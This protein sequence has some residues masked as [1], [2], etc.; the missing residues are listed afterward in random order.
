M[1]YRRKVLASNYDIYHTGCKIITLNSIVDMNNGLEKICYKEI[2]YSCNSFSCYFS[3][4]T[5]EIRNK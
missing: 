3:E 2:I 5:E 4:I 1:K